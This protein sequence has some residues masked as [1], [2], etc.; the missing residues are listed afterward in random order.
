MSTSSEASDALL[1]AGAAN[2]RPAEN[3]HVELDSMASKPALPVEEDIMQLARLGELGAI[4]KLFDTGKFDATYT[5][6]QD[7][8]PL[9]VRLPSLVLHHGQAL[10]N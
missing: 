7:I 2:G 5:D 6:D 9:H 10:R 8:T 3:G 1:P 4:Q